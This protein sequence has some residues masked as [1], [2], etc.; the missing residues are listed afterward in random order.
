MKNKLLL[1]SLSIILALS[2]NKN[3]DHSSK[4]NSASEDVSNAKKKSP[5]VP[6]S[7]FKNN[8][9]GENLVNTV[10]GCG[11]YL[12][13]NYGSPGYY[14]YP[15]YDIDLSSTPQWSTINVNV[16]SYDVP[17]RFT[18]T[19][20]NG[21]LIAY[22]G[23]MG[24]ANY[25]GPWGQSLNTT[26]S[27]TLTFV[28]G[29]TSSFILSVETSVS[30]MSDSW[31]AS[32]GCQSGA[33]IDNLT[34]QQIIDIYS[35]VGVPHNE[36]LDYVLQ[37]LKNYYGPVYHGGNSK[38]AHDLMYQN[39]DNNTKG[40]LTT[41]R[42]VSQSDANSCINNFKNSPV[43]KFG[44][45]LNT[46][47]TYSPYY[48]TLSANFKTAISQLNT[49]VHDETKCY[50]KTNYDAIVNNNI[51]LLPNNNE[52]VYLVSMCN[53]GYNSIIY[54]RDNYSKWQSFFGAPTPMLAN[55]GKDIGIA[56][57]SGI[58]TG[59]IGGCAWG[60]AG[61]TIALPG[62]GTV[63]GCA[64]VGAISA[65]G[66]GLGNSAKKAVESFINWLAR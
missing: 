62:A 65:L 36:G 63:A 12:S 43:K 19:D 11:S 64:G 50:T 31:N 13:G 2:C 60:A 47:I 34:N 54:W 35:N 66:G 17:N 27:Q 38:A 53:V 24:Y 46:N 42:S 30:S 37:G 6:L 8:S 7:L 23:W 26:E 29:T 49:L 20:G 39:V 22:T 58:I 48:S 21:K 59:A 16:Q 32:V 51:A 33:S 4:L 56:D 52:K 45:N 9:S 61:G 15:N 14:R 1:I 10:Y 44:T 5:E 41:K 25:S 3:I 28:K 18:I 40:Y 55:P 57:V